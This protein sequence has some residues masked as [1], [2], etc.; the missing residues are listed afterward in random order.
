MNKLTEAWFEFKGVKS[1]DIGLYITQMPSR[2]LPVMDMNFHK[3]SG[4]SG[5]IRISDGSYEDIQISVQFKMLDVSNWD[6]AVN[7]LRGQGKLRFSDSQLYEYDAV[8]SDPPT[9]QYE[10]HRFDTQAFSVTF[11]CHPF[12]ML[13]TPASDITVSSSGTSITNPGTASSLPRI[14]VTGSGAFS[15][16]IG[17]QTMFFTDVSSGVIIDSELGDVLTYDGSLLANDKASGDLFEIQP[18]Q[19]YVSWVEGGTN[20]QGQAVTGSVTNVVITP[21]WR[22]V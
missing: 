21:R 1:S 20:E 12:R 18:G 11:V 10:M 7:L 22:Y 19:S 4:K 14:K 9:M 5:S 16:S 13:H 15:L 6:S 8:V 17:G 2:E 3:V